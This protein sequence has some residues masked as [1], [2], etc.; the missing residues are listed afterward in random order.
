MMN[1]GDH[2]KSKLSFFGRLA[3][4]VTREVIPFKNFGV[5]ILDNSAVPLYKTDGYFVFSDVKPLPTDYRFHLAAPSYQSRMVEKNL[6]SDSPVELSFA[7]EDELYVF[8]DDVQNGTEKRVTFGTIPFLKTIPPGAAVY[9]ENGF[10][11]TLAAALE[12]ENIGFAVLDD[13]AG[14][15][16]GELLRFVRSSNIIMRPGPYYR[17]N[18]GTTVAALKFSDNST[19]GQPVPAGVRCEIIEVNDTAIS[20]TSVGGLEVK[21]VTPG[22]TGLVLGAEKDI[23]AYSDERGYCVFYYP[24][25]TPI[26][27]LKLDISADGYNSLLKEVTVTPGSRE[28]QWLE[29]TKI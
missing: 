16:A 9:G 23:T 1:N 4:E 18:P 13:I 14:L 24:A 6:P 7:G 26:V 10:S 11:T 8:I 20:S 15:S 3:D 12:G 21:T 2:F 17:F 28:F 19:P 22:G 29:L 27:K 5:S 25:N